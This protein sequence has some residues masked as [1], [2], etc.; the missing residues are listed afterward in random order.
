MYVAD[1]S[2]ATNI[3]TSSTAHYKY[4]YDALLQNAYQFLRRTAASSGKSGYTILHR[5]TP[6]LK[7]RSNATGDF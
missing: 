7:N 2:R 3:L 1:T 6:L 5:E 4:E